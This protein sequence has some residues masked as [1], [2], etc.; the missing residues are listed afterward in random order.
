[1]VVDGL[2]QKSGANSRKP[3]NEMSDGLPGMVDM[4]Q[5]D[6]WKLILWTYSTFVLGSVD[7]ATG[8]SKISEPSTVATRPPEGPAGIVKDVQTIEA[9][10]R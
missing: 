5:V 1:M 8:F 3:K 7:I 6:Q 10:F 9:N 4:F 2:L